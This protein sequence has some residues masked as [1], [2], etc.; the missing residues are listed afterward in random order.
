MNEANEVDK[1]GMRLID[2]LMLMVLSSSLFVDECIMFKFKG[3]KIDGFDRIIGVDR[4]WITLYTPLL[5]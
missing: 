4:K 5:Y 1:D 3:G 2:A